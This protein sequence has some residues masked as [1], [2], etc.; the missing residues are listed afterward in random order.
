MRMF[1]R[2]DKDGYCLGF[3]ISGDPAMKGI[4]GYVEITNS[5]EK[6]LISANPR[7]YRRPPDKLVSPSKV[8]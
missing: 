5:R 2:F 6:E 4:E 1:A 3:I 7:R 8:G